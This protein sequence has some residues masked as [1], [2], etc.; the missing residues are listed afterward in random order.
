[1]LEKV[2][3]DDPSTYLRVLSAIAP[4]QVELGMT[5]SLADFLLQLN[6]KKPNVIDGS[7]ADEAEIVE[8]RSGAVLPG[9]S[10]A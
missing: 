6:E 10:G 4:K 5:D 8:T 2:R 3:A 9:G 1:V 7:I